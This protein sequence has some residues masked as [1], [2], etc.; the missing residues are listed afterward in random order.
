ML[1]EERK[2]II[3]EI[4]DKNKSAKVN[5]LSKHLHITEATVRRDLDEL[6]NEKKIRRTHGG[7]ISLYPSS[8]ESGI[9]EYNVKMIN[10]KRMIAHKAYEFVHD[11]DAIIVDAS[12]TVM[13]LVKLIAV[14]DKKNITIVTN[15]FKAVQILMQKQT[16]KVIQIGGSAVVSRNATSGPI[17]ERILND[18]RADKVFLGINGIDGVYGYSVPGFD[19]ASLKRC[20]LKAAKQ[21]FVLADH[22]KF[23]ESYLGKV[24][25]IIGEIDYLITDSFPKKLKLEALEQQ[26]NLIVGE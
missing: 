17:A 24:A 5:E 8:F 10:E 11:N 2:R 4:I 7:A 12:T 18:L 26:V 16:M 13:E 1:A 22:S 19:D 9:Q 14:G 25:E 15:S 6:Q 23:G 21:S 3:L 20:M